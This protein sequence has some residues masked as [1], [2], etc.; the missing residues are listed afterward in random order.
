M[1]IILP[2]SNS[3]YFN[4]ALEEFFLKNLEEDVFFAWKCSPSV[5]LGKH[6]NVYEEV[7]IDFTLQHKINIA[8]RIS[9]GGTVFHDEGNVNF[10]FIK[11][12]EKEKLVDFKKHTQP[13]IDILQDMGIDAKFQG[14][15]DLRVDGKK[16]SGNAEH[17]YKNKVL[18]HGTLLFK[19]DLALLRGC[20]KSNDPGY[21]SK[22]VKS[23]RS[24]VENIAELLNDQMTV[25][26][27]TSKL[28]EGIKTHFPGSRMYML[29]SHEIKEIE[30]L[31]QKKYQSWEWVYG[32][33]PK[34]K[35][36]REKRMNGDLVTTELFVVDGMIEDIKIEVNGKE[37]NALQ[38][39]LKG[40]KHHPSCLKERIWYMNTF[41][42]ENNEFFLKLLY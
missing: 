28:V 14:K 19:S 15:N 3:I 36:R 42:R 8:R 33:S 30:K 37:N 22:A 6:Q 7:D 29:N 16:I 41:H 11:S 35:L 39:I 10:T 38:T 24:P 21:E 17:V 27:F 1:L 12:G 13:V 20:L 4:L 18:H 32:Y 26:D 31:A 5:V 25:D 9:G 2:R 34:Y 23:V 40:T